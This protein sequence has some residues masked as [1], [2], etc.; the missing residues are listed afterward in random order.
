MTF[1]IEDRVVDWDNSLHIE[2][3][4]KENDL[5]PIPPESRFTGPGEL[6]AFKYLE[7]CNRTGKPFDY[8]WNT[9]IEKLEYVFVKQCYFGNYTSQSISIFSYNEDHEDYKSMVKGINKD[10]LLN[11]IKYRDKLIILLDHFSFLTPK[12]AYGDV[13]NGI[14]RDDYHVDRVGYFTIYENPEQE[15]EFLKDKILSF[16]EMIKDDLEMWT[17]KKCE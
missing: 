5:C 11:R 4:L 13:E 10:E 16:C 7:E 8:K 17:D 15:Y 12:F 9:S 14:S 2:D 1:E 3:I 6:E